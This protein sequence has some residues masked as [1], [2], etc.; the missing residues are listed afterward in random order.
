LT[1]GEA[2]EYMKTGET[3][4]INDFIS[5]YGRPFTAKLKMKDDGRH[6][7]EFMP[8]GEGAG[9]GKGRGRFGKKKAGEE[10]TTES[11][12]EAKAEKPKKAPAKKKVVKKATK[13]TAAKKKKAATE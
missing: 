7:F 5:R 10:A 4:F 11:T 13:K 12:T 3:P 1:R 9:K 6:S 8:R 2:I